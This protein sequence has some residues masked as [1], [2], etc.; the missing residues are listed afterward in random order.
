MENFFHTLSW[1][2]NSEFFSNYVEGI[3]TFFKLLEE[4]VFSESRV[5]QSL[6]ANLEQF[7]LVHYLFSK[8]F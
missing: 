7:S 3:Q 6:G 1:A 8:V 5:I 2:K 4:Y